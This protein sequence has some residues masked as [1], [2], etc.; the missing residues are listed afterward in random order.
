M[1]KTHKEGSKKITKWVH[2]GLQSCIGGAEKTKLFMIT[3]V[4]E[5]NTKVFVS[6]EIREE[7]DVKDLEEATDLY[8]RLTCGS[9]RKAWKPNELAHKYNPKNSVRDEY[10]KVNNI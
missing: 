4:K 5:G 7:F 9:G 1:T 10:L 6:H 8:E 2:V 3:D